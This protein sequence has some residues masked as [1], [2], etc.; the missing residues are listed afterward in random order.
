MK[1]VAGLVILIAAL[2]A[3]PLGAASPTGTP[4]TGG[5]AQIVNFGSILPVVNETG[6]ISLSEDAVGS[7]DVAGATLTIEKPTGATVR[8]AYMAAATTGFSGAVLA[9]GDVTIDGA[10]VNW[11]A[12]TPNGISSNNYWSDV[13]TLVKTKLDGAPA[14]AVSFQIGET[15]A[16]TTEGEIL[17]VIFDDPN[18]TTSN[19]IALLFGAQNLA[20]DT[21][22]IGLAEPIDKSDPKLRLDMALGISFGFQGL[23]QYSTVEVNAQRLSSAAGGQDDG[24]G[25]DGALI[26]V[27]GVGDSNANPADANATPNGDPRFD[28]ELYNLLPFVATGDTQI[29]VFTQNPS[30][31][32]NI[33]FA[34]LVL[35]STTA[36]VGEGIVLGPIDAKNPVNASHTLTATVQDS[37]GS[38]VA[39]RTVTFT[40][41]SGPNAGTTGTG[42]T[43]PDGKATFT[44]SSS[45]TGVDEIQASFLD[46]AGNT[47]LSNVARKEWTQTQAD[48][49]LTKTDAPDP[50]TVGG[51]LTYT[52]TVTNQGPDP[53]TDST[54]TD[55]LPAGVTFVSVIPSQ[56]VCSSPLPGSPVICSL[57]PL[58]VGASATI[59]IVATVDPTA[60]SPL[61]DTATVAGIEA[62]PVQDNNSATAETTISSPQ[63]DH[64]KC[65]K[66]K[67]LGAKFDPRRVVLTDQFNT[68][69]VNVVRPEAF[70]NPVDKDGSGINDP[71]AHLTCYK[72]HDVRGDEF[73]K[74]EPRRIN[75]RDQFGVRNLGVR[76]T[77]RLCL[78]PPEPVHPPGPAACVDTDNNGS[79][80]NDGDALCDNWE[81][82]G[83]DGDNDG[84]ADL[85]LYDM[86]GDGAIDPS[87]R[88]D[89]NHKDIYLEIDFMELHQPD[90]G[91]LA[92]VVASFAAA[93]VSNPAGGSGVALHIQTDEQALVHNDD[94]AFPPCTA[95]APSGVPDFDVAKSASFGTAAERGAGA[96]VTNAKRFAFHYS[97]FVHN[98]LG[99]DGTSGCAEIFGNDFIVSLGSW[100]AVGGHPVGTRDE[101]AGTLMHEFGHN[102]NLRHGGAD[103][104]NCKPN[105]LSV[106]TYTR[107]I[108][109]APISGRPLDYSRSALPTLDEASLSEP[110]GVAGPVGDQTAYGPPPRQVAP[111]DGPIDWNRDSDTGDSGVSADINNVGIGGCA[112]TGTVLQ[113]HDD[114][115]NLRYDFQNSGDFVDGVHLSVIGELEITFAEVQELRGI[116]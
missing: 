19:T 6:L 87:E 71:T 75:A 26:T 72:I 52:L 37:N 67:Q 73:P 28:D 69:R 7:N 82:V 46:S 13:T 24:Q 58:A 66:T 116:D 92:D 14:G 113:G 59:G 45:T 102:L 65:Y 51:N 42:V 38:P 30:N 25:V 68:E 31:D 2:L 62:D 93:P 20:G 18:Q 79:A 70:C 99:L 80:D 33:F 77:R 21:F 98:L 111:A 16:L 4:G 95:T 100:T 97:L 3:I 56:G 57:G 9:N 47:V 109:G 17:A 60:V 104:I 84:V 86:N 44:Y 1:L 55:T 114:W 85:Q 54:V 76:K 107:Q 94:L 110:A 78:P 27:G 89:L 8:K 63:L 74:F 88:A 35:N 101:Q 5:P 34:A 61:S 91:A 10:G 40:V 64:F 96:A 15:N 50:V 22:N 32:D 39:G 108:N 112:G 43:G 41:I 36:V 83:L 53:S 106:M 11:D 23:D 115:A 49:S 12:T 103:D 90:P 29:T 81:T 105:Y 48:L